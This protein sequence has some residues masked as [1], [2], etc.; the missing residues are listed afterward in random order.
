MPGTYRS[1]R[2]GSA[3]LGVSKD[4]G[5]LLP[6]LSSVAVL[7]LQCQSQAACTQ[8]PARPLVVGPLGKVMTPSEPQCPP[9]CGWFTGCPE[10]SVGGGVAGWGIP[11]TASGRGWY[12]GRR[13]AVAPSEHLVLIVSQ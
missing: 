6:Q 9:R 3:A 7:S 12:W 4:T 13:G 5:H 10:V 2:S 8:V 1:G 11:G